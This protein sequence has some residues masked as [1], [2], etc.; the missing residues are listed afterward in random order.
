VESRKAPTSNESDQFPSPVPTPFGP[1]VQLKNVTANH[2]Y[3]YRDVRHC[4][5]RSGRNWQ[6]VPGAEVKIEE[7]REIKSPHES[8]LN[9]P[10]TKARRG[11]ST[12]AIFQQECL[13]GGKERSKRSTAFGE[14]L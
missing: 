7:I 10:I 5:S 12:S 2:R 9:S 6:R 1:L 3:F 4:E 14:L 8:G 13:Y 11:V